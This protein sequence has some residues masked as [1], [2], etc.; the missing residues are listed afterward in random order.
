MHHAPG[1]G[2]TLAILEAG[3]YAQTVVT[4]G[5][6]PAMIAAEMR[7]RDETLVFPFVREVE[8]EGDHVAQVLVVPLAVA[9]S[10][11]LHLLLSHVVALLM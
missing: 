6:P 10:F 1:A 4:V 11:A 2:T 7:F 3:R 8:A 5:R 9:V